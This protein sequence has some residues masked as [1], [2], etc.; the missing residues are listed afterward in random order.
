MINQISNFQA[1]QKNLALGTVAKSEIEQY[2]SDR[3]SNNPTPPSPQKTAL[4]MGDNLVQP[5]GPALRRILP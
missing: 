5:I 2:I 1:K 3:P 4:V